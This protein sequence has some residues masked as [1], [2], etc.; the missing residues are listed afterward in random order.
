[1]PSGGDLSW[2]ISNLVILALELEVNI[3]KETALYKWI[4]VIYLNYQ[5]DLSSQV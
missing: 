5:I 3:K 1:M 4:S 2:E